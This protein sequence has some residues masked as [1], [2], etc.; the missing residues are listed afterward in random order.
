MNNQ[1]MSHGECIKVLQRAI[2]VGE[3]INVKA[4]PLINARN[5]VAGNRGD[6]PGALASGVLM[7]ITG[8]LLANIYVVCKGKGHNL[9]TDKAALAMASY[10]LAM[11][12]K[13][14]RF[15]AYFWEEKWNKV[16]M[17]LTT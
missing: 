15:R 13:E 17:F 16:R 12:E 8:E 11:S 6:S 5:A 4:S 14:F 9:R 10:L 1:K 2:T 7:R 3:S